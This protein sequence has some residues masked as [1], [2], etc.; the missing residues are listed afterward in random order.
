MN[1]HVDR[2]IALVKHR[3][4]LDALGPDDDFYQAGVDSVEA[5]DILMDLEGEFGVAVPD[6]QFV[7]A[8]TP[9]AVAALIAQAAA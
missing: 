1:S 7:T 9:R 4:R 2:V 3:G 6:E 5:I 8:R